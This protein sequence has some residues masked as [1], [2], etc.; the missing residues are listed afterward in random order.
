MPGAAARGWLSLAARS[1]RGGTTGRAAGCPASGRA[2]GL[3]AD[4]IGAPGARPATPGL[5]KM[6]A[7][8]DIGSLMPGGIGWRGPDSTWPGR[9]GGTGRA[10]GGIGRPGAITAA[11]G[12]GDGG[13]GAGREMAGAEGGTLGVCGCTPGGALPAN[14]GRIG[15]AGRPAGRSSAGLAATASGAFSSTAAG[16]GWL[17]GPLGAVS[18]ACD[19]STAGAGCAEGAAGRDSSSACPSGTSWPKK[20]R[21]LRATSSSIELEWVF[22]SVTPNSGSLSMISCAL[23]SSSRASSLIRIL[24]IDAKLSRR[25]APYSLCEPPSSDPS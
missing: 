6:G 14:G 18:A 16:A 22:F 4:G 10:T 24:F 5:L 17:A 8:G 2:G 7:E 3:G 21:S 12:V 19:L 13:A 20:R 1:A 25:G 9:D 23:T 11:G 15:C